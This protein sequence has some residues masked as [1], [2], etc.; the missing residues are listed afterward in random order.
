MVGSGARA[1]S[2]SHR[3]NIIMKT[4]N[5]KLTRKP[6]AKSQRMMGAL[7]CAS[8]EVARPPSAGPLSSVFFSLLGGSS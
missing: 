2:K 4:R 1:L 6:A 8:S 7:A 5:P 3:P